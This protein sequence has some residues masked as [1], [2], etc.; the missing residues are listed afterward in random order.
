MAS[1]GN[2]IR[3]GIAVSIFSDNVTRQE[4]M[5]LAFSDNIIR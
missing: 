1:V 3:W 4:A 5:G 2:V